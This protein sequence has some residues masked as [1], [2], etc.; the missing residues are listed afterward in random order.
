MHSS[1]VN[2][3]WMCEYKSCDIFAAAM[4]VRP[5]SSASAEAPSSR[6]REKPDSAREFEIQSADRDRS[7]NNVDA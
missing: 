4:A 7:V 3:W 1:T 6:Q 2:F 5:S